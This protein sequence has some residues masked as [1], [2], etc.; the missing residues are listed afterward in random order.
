MNKFICCLFFLTTK[1]LHNIVFNIFSMKEGDHKG[2]N[3]QSPPKSKSSLD[4]KSFSL[5][6]FI[7]FFMVITIKMLAHS[8]QHQ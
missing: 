5:S 1:Q 8:M 6:L 7:I 4:L 2:K 3:A